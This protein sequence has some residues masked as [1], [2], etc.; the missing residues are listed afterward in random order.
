LPVSAK[1]VYWIETLPNQLPYLIVGLLQEEDNPAT[2]R[3]MAWRLKKIMAVT[4]TT[5]HPWGDD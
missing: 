5:E 4:V 1:L 2:A 3:K